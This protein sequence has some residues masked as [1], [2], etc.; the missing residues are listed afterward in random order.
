[1]NSCPP[2]PPTP[3]CYRSSLVSPFRQKGAP[4]GSKLEGFFFFFFFFFVFTCN[5]KK[6]TIMYVY[7]TALCREEGYFFQKDLLD[8]LGART[9]QHTSNIQHQRIHLTHRQF[10]SLQQHPTLV[11]ISCVRYADTFFTKDE[12]EECFDL[13][14]WRKASLPASLLSPQLPF[15]PISSRQFT[16]TPILF[17]TSSFTKVPF[18]TSLFH[19]SSFTKVPFHTSPL[20]PKRPLSE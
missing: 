9:I 3:M 2:Q 6:C 10:L 5:G 12:F 4:K 7:P 17:H 14:L 20:S 16:F 11:C 18:H 13:E 19:T 1:L 15:P 8:N